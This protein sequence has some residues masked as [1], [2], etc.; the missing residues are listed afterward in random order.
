MSKT[1]SRQ[2]I[3]TDLV[4]GD[5]NRCCPKCFSADQIILHGYTDTHETFS[6]AHCKEVWTVA[7]QITLVIKVS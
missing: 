6:C 7:Y 5:N 4:G 1:Q 3:I 2:K